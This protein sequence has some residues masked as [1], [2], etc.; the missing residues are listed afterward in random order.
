MRTQLLAK[1]AIKRQWFIV[2]AKGQTLGRLSARVAAVLIGK[3]KP[4]FTPHADCGDYVIVV[5]AEQVHLTGKKWTDKLYR[6]HTQYPGGL[7]TQ[8]AGDIK[9]VDIT[10]V[11]TPQPA[12]APSAQPPAATPTP[13]TTTSPIPMPTRR[14]VVTVS[15]PGGSAPRPAR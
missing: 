4:D 2:D 7:L 3:H 9:P 14:P 8:T 5:N 12:A 1:D 13:T 11:V 6:H 10:G 15:H